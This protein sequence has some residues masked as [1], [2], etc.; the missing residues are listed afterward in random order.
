MGPA[1]AHSLLADEARALL[2][3]LDRVR[4]FALQETMVPAAA[5][6]ARALHAIEEHLGA[7]R[8]ALREEL[9]GY[10]AWMAGE[11][12]RV[13]PAEAQGRLT[14]LR[15]RFN[16]LLSHV[17][18]FAD[19]LS[20]RSER[21]TGIWL[22]GL[23]VAAADALD[24][25]PHYEAPP[26]LCYLDRGR[27]GAI[28]R[29]HT[30]LPGGGDNP[31]AIIRVPRERMIGAGIASSLAHEAGHQGAALLDLVPSLRGVLGAMTRAPGR[32][33]LA[34]CLWERWASEIVADLWAL[35]RVGIASTLGLITIVSL[36][37][38]FVY[39]VSTVDPHPAP[40]IRVLLS[41][42]VGEALY[43]DAR[44]RRL[45]GIWEEMYPLEQAPPQARALLGLLKSTLPVVAPLLAEHRP[46]SLG[47]RAL[48]EV[49]ASADRTPARLAALGPRLGGS[50]QAYAALRPSIAFAVI[51]QG[52]VDGTVTPE[53]ES[54]L[55]GQLM[56]AWALDTAIERVRAC[57][58]RT[59]ARASSLVGGRVF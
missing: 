49:L 4:S 39:R 22:S 5:I 41:A 46:R 13:T 35:G 42:A 31:V 55:L 29:A 28:R 20:Q 1:A 26:L 38:A 6:S 14:T 10:V 56:E 15:L 7:K 8:R 40:W 50:A 43:P 16:V 17:D 2:T 21:D 18:L 3:R 57:A 34:W 54:E 59:R 32:E 47:G 33:A 12:S 52:R 24:I 53:Q 9:A 23:E 45:A 36:P 19:A 37:K 58:Q 30:R 48:S 44:W 25:G 27:G 51:G 11:G